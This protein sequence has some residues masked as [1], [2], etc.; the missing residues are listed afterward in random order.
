MNIPLTIG[1]QPAPKIGDLLLSEPF[2][3]DDHF[4]RSVILICAH[5]KQDGTLGLVLNNTLEMHMSELSMGFPKIDFTIGMGGPVDPT[6]LFFLHKNAEL[7]GAQK[8]TESLYF[9][10]DYTALLSE[11]ITNT[12]KK[13]IRFFIGYTGWESNQLENELIE[14][15]W[16]VMQPPEDFNV[17]N[18]DDDHLWKSLISGLGGKYKLMADYPI[19]PTD[20]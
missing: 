9:G 15:S 7:D 5:S 14:G 3:V 4:T 8:I 10:G 16:I 20:N 2:L 17:F 1:K 19:N 11:I 12:L 6:Q 18:T 13:D